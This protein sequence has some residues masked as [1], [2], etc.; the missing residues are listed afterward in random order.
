M[1]LG[2]DDDSDVDEEVDGIPPRERWLAS[3]GKDGKVALWGLID[4]SASG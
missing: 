4:F 1:D 2:D 3:G